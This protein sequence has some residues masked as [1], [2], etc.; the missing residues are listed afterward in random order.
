M[1]LTNAL[2]AQNIGQVYYYVTPVYSDT[3]SV[4]PD[5]TPDKVGP[6]GWAGALPNLEYAMPNK[7]HIVAI[8]TTGLS[9]DACIPN[10]NDQGGQILYGDPCL[11]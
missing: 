3:P 1:T 10:T 5:P 6:Q 9:L 2:R 7:I 4:L 8:S 11:A